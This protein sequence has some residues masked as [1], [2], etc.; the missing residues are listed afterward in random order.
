MD[1][2]S[3]RKR[4]NIMKAIRAK[5]TIIEKRFRK[6]A[7]TL[8]Y[9]FITNDS[10][11]IG[12]PD[13]VFSKQKVVVFVDSCFWHGCPTHCR[14]PKSNKSY[15]YDKILCNKKRDKHVSKQLRHNE[16]KVLRFWEHSIN[17]DLEG[18]INKISREL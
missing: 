15:W 4:S 1:N 12:K 3:K 10:R 8:K 11:L 18:C 7:R 17:S 6:A 14:K 13:I 2:V 16:W 9:K 5:G